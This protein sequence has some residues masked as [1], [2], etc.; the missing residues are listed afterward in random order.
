MRALLHTLVPNAAS[1]LL[2]HFVAV[3]PSTANSSGMSILQILAHE[4]GHIYWFDTFVVD[5][6]KQFQASPGGFAVVASPVSQCFSSN[7]SWTYPVDVPPGRWLDFGEIRNVDGNSELL[8]LPGL[9]NEKHTDEFASHLRNIYTGGRW[10]GLFGAFSTDEDF[11]TTLELSVILNATPSLQ[12]L[13]LVI[14]RAN[15]KSFTIP[16]ILDNVNSATELGKKYQCF[17]R[18]PALARAR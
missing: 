2:P 5:P 15:G 17:A 1:A 8:Q 18:L 9:L 11:V 10:V 16:N 7:A 13:T 12:S 3:E 6:G 4:A 14:P